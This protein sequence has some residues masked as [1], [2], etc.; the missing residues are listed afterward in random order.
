MEILNTVFTLTDG[1]TYT[2]NLPRPKAEIT[3]E[4]VEAW[5]RHMIEADALIVDGR[6]LSGIEEAYIHYTEMEELY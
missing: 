4:K 3:Q 2:M 1:K 5:M 6:H